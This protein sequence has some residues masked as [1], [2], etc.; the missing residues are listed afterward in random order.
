M[1][2]ETFEQAKALTDGL[3]SLSDL[4]FTVKRANL[5]KGSA[6]DLAAAKKQFEINKKLSIVSATISG[7]Q[8][9]VNALSAQ[10]VIPEPFGTILKVASAVAVG[11]AAAT[12]IAK[13]ASTSFDGGGGGGG[14]AAASSA[15]AG[16]AGVAINSPT[17]AS[18]LLNA[19]GSIK[20]NGTKAPEPQKVVVVE[21]DITN[22]QNRVAMLQ[23]NSKY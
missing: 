10:S 2:Q 22:K 5:K 8:G 16:A 21:S 3:K 4:Y 11:I 23:E 18:T 20:S 7:I 9:V 17:T 14:G 6:E 15:G 12:N 13:I 1:T 19:D